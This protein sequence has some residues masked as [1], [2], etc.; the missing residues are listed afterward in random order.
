MN[1]ELRNQAIDAI[2]QAILTETGSQKSGGIN[3]AGIARL[4]EAYAWLA[5][6]NNPHGG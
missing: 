6:P 2:L 5:A 3:S 4:A 1:E